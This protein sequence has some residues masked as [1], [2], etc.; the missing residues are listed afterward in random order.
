MSLAE[1]IKSYGAKKRELVKKN[2]W[3]YY[4]TGAGNAMM[5]VGAELSKFEKATAANKLSHKQF[6]KGAEILNIDPTQLEGTTFDT[7]NE[8]TSRWGNFKEGIRERLTSAKSMT[9]AGDTKPDKWYNPS[10]WGNQADPSDSGKFIGGKGGDREYTAEEISQVGMI[11][12]DT[13]KAKMAR[14]VYD[15]EKGE[16]GKE[17]S[18][19]F[20]AY[21]EK[22]GADIGE[23]HHVI[24]QKTRVENEN[25]VKKVTPIIEAK[26]SKVEVDPD[27]DFSSSD[28][29]GL[30]DFY[31]DK[32][33]PTEG[34]V[35]TPRE[36]LDVRLRGVDPKTGYPF[37]KSADDYDYED[38]YNEPEA[39]EQPD[40]VEHKTDETTV[41]VDPA[42][43]LIENDNKE[44][45]ILKPDAA[46]GYENLSLSD[47]RLMAGY[48]KEFGETGPVLEKYAD[49]QHSDTANKMRGMQRIMNELGLDVGGDT[50]E[51]LQFGGDAFG[52]NSKNAYNLLRTQWSDKDEK[53]WGY[54]VE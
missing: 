8:E 24:N 27:D 47:K 44:T 54:T 50:A 53:E 13:A 20:G 28:G 25:S 15:A 52:K 29:L 32:T 17:I 5:K 43:I 33:T 26:K 39:E 41:K 12:G 3:S 19:L 38:L 1:S 40:K 2:K 4:A 21:I 11:Y 18:E 9:T 16:E 48:F 36:R 30:D 31:A 35:K 45:N 46:K 34:R 23:P 37:G 49:L 7:P 10:S 42:K 6:Q 51:W 22:P 14:A